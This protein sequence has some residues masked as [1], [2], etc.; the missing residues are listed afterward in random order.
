MGDVFK[1]PL[2]I[3]GPEADKTNL[4]K[5]Y[6]SLHASIRK[7]DNT[8]IIFFEPA[9]GGNEVGAFPTGL[10][11]G[12]GGA[13][14]NDRQALTYHIYCPWLET[15]MPYKNKSLEQFDQDLCD[16]LNELEYDIRISDTKRLGVGG[17]LT[18]F[19]AEVQDKFGLEYLHHSMRKLDEA[20]HSWT[21]WYLTPDAAKPNFEARALTRT[22]PHAVGGSLI[23]LS[24]NETTAAFSMQL[25]PAGVTP[26][27]AAM[28]TE[29]FASSEFH[30]PSGLEWSVTP[31]GAMKGAYNASSGLLTL[32]PTYGVGRGTQDAPGGATDV[33]PAVVTV[34]IT[35]K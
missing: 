20:I 3:Y 12:P 5:F 8:S 23:N 19:G 18:E 7:V 6:A 34:A 29:V 26:A 28:Q 15:D 30:Y 14:Y 33:F 31:V 32:T 4:Q 2:L 17:F 22:Y 27:A 24:F 13:A 25:S 35:P 11:E 16:V 9:T 21:Y 1:N 10:T